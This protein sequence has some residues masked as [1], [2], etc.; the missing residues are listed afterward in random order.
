[1]N[2][3]TILKKY[4]LRGLT[5]SQFS[6]LT[7]SM[8]KSWFKYNIKREDGIEK[9][10]RVLNY[11]T[12]KP[13]SG[14]LMEFC[15]KKFK[16]NKSTYSHIIY[17]GLILRT[18]NAF[19]PENIGNWRPIIQE[20][21][22][23]QDKKAKD[24]E[25]LDFLSKYLSVREKHKLVRDIIN[26][27]PEELI[28]LSPKLIP[29]KYKKD[30]ANILMT[31]GDRTW[32]KSE[33]Y[34]IIK[35]GDYDNQVKF[36]TNSILNHVYGTPELIDNLKLKDRIV[37]YKKI[38]LDKPNKQMWFLGKIP[39]KSL[40]DGIINALNNDT[41]VWGILLE[42][43]RDPAKNMDTINEIP[44]NLQILLFENIFELGHPMY[45]I[46]DIYKY[47]KNDKVLDYI[48]DRVS[49]IEITQ[50]TISAY[51]YT[52][53]GNFNEPLE[54]RDDDDRLLRTMKKAYKEQH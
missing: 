9:F 19:K 41:N 2:K 5:S 8:Q 32:I 40:K 33:H 7:P 48:N 11:K 42:V 46:K 22:K 4:I 34:D 44:T 10:H 49:K 15:E 50:S 14:P 47:I 37:L 13:F 29:D 28:S 54:Y 1:M 51:G 12:M 16:S 35:F 23:K 45:N 53:K 31:K 38:P 26:K 6:K 20:I 43:M 39:I 30:Y 3:K 36:I 17:A 24:Y 52:L 27:N 25:R 21:L 18:L